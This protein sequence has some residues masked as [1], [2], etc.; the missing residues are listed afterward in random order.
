VSLTCSATRWHGGMSRWHV[1]LGPLGVRNFLQGFF[2]SPNQLRCFR[3]LRCKTVIIQ[4]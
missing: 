2:H 4:K 3:T 1:D